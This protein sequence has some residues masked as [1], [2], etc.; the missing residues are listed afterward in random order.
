MFQNST[1]CGQCIHTRG[2]HSIKVWET[3][4]EIWHCV[5]DDCA[6]TICMTCPHN[7]NCFPLLTLSLSFNS[8]MIYPT[9]MSFYFLKWS[10]ATRFKSSAV[11]QCMLHRV[12]R[13]D[14]RLR[15]YSTWRFTHCSSPRSNF[16]NSGAGGISDRFSS[17]WSVTSVRRPVMFIIIRYQIQKWRVV[18][19]FACFGNF[20][21]K[22]RIQ[23]PR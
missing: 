10:K 8:S 17:S 15:E 13:S 21:W 6:N 16:S 23:H 5:T 11:L 12:L 3:C 7:R 2:E 14:T 9:G 4:G 20:F 19:Y 1:D 18:I 22:K